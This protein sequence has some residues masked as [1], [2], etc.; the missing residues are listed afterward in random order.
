V[1][2]DADVTNSPDDQIAKAVF[3]GKA[4]DTGATEG[5]FKWAAW[6]LDSVTEGSAKTFEDVKEQLKTE[7]TSE[8]AKNRVYEIMGD[9]EGARADGMTLDEAAEAQNLVTFSLPPV[10]ARGGDENLQ[11]VDLYASSPEILQTLFSLDE[12]VESEIEETANGDFYA[13]T[14]D[15]VVPTRTPELDDILE[16]VKAA[17]MTREAANAMRALADA[18]KADLEAG[19]TADQ[20]TASYPGSRVEISI[21]SRYQQEPSI[22][23]NLARA[24]FSANPGQAISSVMPSTN[25]VVVSRLTT[26]IPSPPIADQTLMLLGTRMDQELAQDIESQFVN[27]LRNAYTIRRDDR[28]KA[29]AL[30]DG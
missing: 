14:V 6:K 13:L 21:L 12:L 8:E 9:F 29:L 28:L 26:I 2:T 15:E 20:I 30:G 1:L 11:V 17:Y 10:D 19:K 5:R 3:E 16:T 27:G 7:Y 23:P 18:V 22:P 24:L 4:G 25:E